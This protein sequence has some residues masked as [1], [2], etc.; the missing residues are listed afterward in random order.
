MI[1]DDALN[2]YCDGSSY[3]KPR[4]G[5]IGIRFVY[6]NDAGDEE[7]Q[8]FDFPGYQN[9]TNNQMELQA[10]I[11][12][13]KEA[14]KYRE[15]ANF[16]KV[17]IHSDSLYVVDNYKK[18]MF[19]WPNTK[20]SS[21][22]GRPV[23]NAELWKDLVKTIKN[24]KMRVEINWVKGHSKDK[25][26]KDVDKLAKK[27]AQNPINKPLTVVEVRRKKTQKSVEIGCI[28]MKGQRIS[29]RI[30]TAEFLKTQKIHKYKYEVLSK[31]SK[32]FENVD[33]V[34]SKEF[35][36]AGHCYIVSFNKNTANP[37]ILKVLGESKK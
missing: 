35:L 29:V 36:K 11:F 15:L 28:K 8:N 21:Q 32:Y 20:W 23:L 5:G 22:T 25:H 31:G 1:V 34:F 9:A 37:L 26:N 12:A 18:A 7:M 2:I 33:I 13:L 4:V 3:S 14:Q 17:V 19:T 24:C 6:I 27:S 16:S 10:C 30:I